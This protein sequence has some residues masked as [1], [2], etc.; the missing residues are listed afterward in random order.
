[1][2]VCISHKTICKPGHRPM[3][4]GRELDLDQAARCRRELPARGQG[5][6]ARCHRERQVRDPGQA[7]PDRRERPAQD[8]G[9]VVLYHRGHPAQAHGKI[10]SCWIHCSGY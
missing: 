3:A 6:A 1:L 9:R 4:G 5:Q 8:Q 7:A 10:T 2:P